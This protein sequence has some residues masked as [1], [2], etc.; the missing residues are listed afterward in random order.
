M[1]V[2]CL[3]TG[4]HPTFKIKLYTDETLKRALVRSLEII[5]EATKKIPADFKI[6]WNLIN[7]KNMAGMREHCPCQVHLHLI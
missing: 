3:P 4:R 7:W 2:P 5:V 6:K 1:W